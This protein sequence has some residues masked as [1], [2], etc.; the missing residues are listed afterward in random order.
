MVAG[1]STGGVEA[2]QVLVGGLPE[3]LPAA[4][5]VV[6]HIPAEAPSALPRILDRAGPFSAGHF[7]DGAK[8]EHGKVYV[9]PPDHH[10]TLERGRIRHSHGPKENRL[11]PAVD[12]LF[13]SAARA[14]GPR[15]VGVVLTGSLDDGTA[16]LLA[17]KQRGGVAVVQDPEEAM[18]P[19]MPGSALR[20]VE[21]DHRLPLAKIPPLLARL[22]GERVEE[23]GEEIVTENEGGFAANPEKMES[24]GPPSM[25][26]C[27]ECGG[28]LWEVGGGELDRFRCRVGHSYTAEHLINEQDGEIEDALYSALNTLH[29]NA[30]ISERLAERARSQGGAKTVEQF[31]RRAE[32]TRRKADALARLLTGGFSSSA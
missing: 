15:V 22:A 11:R 27:P 14:Y 23:R 30:L 20:H 29:E 6:L 12:A 26:S 1:A 9:A 3:D 24:L 2:L 7:S 19:G 10:L 17:V 8:I 5:F 13:A 28:P 21:V 25:F 18:Y 32:E 4:L 16:G 31:E